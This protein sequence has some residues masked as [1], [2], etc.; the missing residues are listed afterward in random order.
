MNNSRVQGRTD[1]IPAVT[2]RLV[3]QPFQ[4]MRMLV[5]GLYQFQA[6]LSCVS[7]VQQSTT[8]EVQ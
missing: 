8:Y 4:L 3:I 5:E 7:V 1:F 2:S 6:H